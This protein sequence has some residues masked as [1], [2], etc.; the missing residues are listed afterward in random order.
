MFTKHFPDSCD[1]LSDGNAFPENSGHSPQ[2]V[3]RLNERELLFGEARECTAAI[4]LLFDCDGEEKTGSS[5]FVNV[6]E[7]AHGL[8]MVG[9]RSRFHS[10][11]PDGGFERKRLFSS[12]IWYRLSKPP[13][14][15][16]RP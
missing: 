9:V 3:L 6:H 8:G 2:G 7:L 12:A 15:G 5:G 16:T 13:F 11:T 10:L 14:Q 1:S 4:V